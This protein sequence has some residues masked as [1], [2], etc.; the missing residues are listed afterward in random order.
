MIDFNKLGKGVKD[1]SSNRNLMGQLKWHK[2]R[3]C[4]KQYK[5]YKTYKS[6]DEC[7]CSAKCY[8]DVHCVTKKKT[9]ILAFF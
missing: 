9:N 8:W 4:E 6:I 1:P 3:A 2:C 7:V 5:S